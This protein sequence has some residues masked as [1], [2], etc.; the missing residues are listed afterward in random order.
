MIEVLIEAIVDCYYKQDNKIEQ[1]NVSI[2]ILI[3]IHVYIVVVIVIV[4][5]FHVATA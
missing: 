2:L 1:K 4:R 5:E 3:C